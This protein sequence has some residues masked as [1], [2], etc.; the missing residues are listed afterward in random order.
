MRSET[1]RVGDRFRDRLRI[2]SW[3]LTSTDSATR[4]RAP[5]GPASRATVANGCR[6]ERLDRAPHTPTKIATPR[7][8][9]EFSNSPRSRAAAHLLAVAV[10]SARTVRQDP[11]THLEAAQ[12]PYPFTLPRRTRIRFRRFCYTLLGFVRLAFLRITMVTAPLMW[13]FVW[14]DQHV[15]AVRNTDTCW[16]LSRSNHDRDPGVSRLTLRGS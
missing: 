12:R 7:H 14:L 5:P 13:P 10:E 1:R 9:H 8:D 2:S 3:C 4:E 6:K 11:T 15:A 16:P